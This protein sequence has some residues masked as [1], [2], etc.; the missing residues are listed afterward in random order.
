[1]EFDVLLDDSIKGILEFFFNYVYDFD[2][3]RKLYDLEEFRKLYFK[4]KRELVLIILLVLFS[5]ICLLYF[6]LVLYY[7][8]CF[9]NYVRWR[10]RWYRG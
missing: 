1:M 5:I 7:C 3:F 8:I 2:Y 6:V 10:L 9:K 4:F